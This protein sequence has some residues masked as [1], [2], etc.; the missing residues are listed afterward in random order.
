MSS[1][2]HPRSA[3]RRQRGEHGAGVCDAGVGL[4]DQSHCLGGYGERGWYLLL[5]LLALL[6]AWRGARCVLMFV[7]FLDYEAIGGQRAP[8]PSM[9]ALSHTLDLLPL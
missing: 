4:D 2:H 8:G 9:T 1:R 6:A 7:F 3:D 5:A